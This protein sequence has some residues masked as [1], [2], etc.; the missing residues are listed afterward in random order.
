MLDRPNKTFVVGNLSR[1]VHI[2]NHGRQEYKRPVPYTDPKKESITCY[3]QVYDKLQINGP[4]GYRLNASELRNFPFTDVFTQVNLTMSD[5]G[6]LHLTDEELAEV[7]SSVTRFFEPTPRRRRTANTTESNIA[8]DQSHTS[9]DNGIVRLQVHPEQQSEGGP[10]RS[11]RVRTA[12]VYD[13]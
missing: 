11:G 3:F 4:C 2:G 12:I 6:T 13:P 7:T 5:D 8:R 9:S 10:R 1:M